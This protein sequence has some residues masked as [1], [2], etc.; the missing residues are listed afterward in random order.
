MRSAQ[1]RRFAQRLLRL[2][3][4]VALM[5]TKPGWG[6]LAPVTM[7]VSMGKSGKHTVA[8]GPR[9]ADVVVW[10]RALDPA[11]KA[12]EP[13]LTE[14]P[15]LTQFHKSFHPHLLVI[16]V[17]TVVD[18]PNRDPFFHN[19]FSLFEGKRIDL[20]LYEAGATNSVRFDRAGVSFLFCN[21]HPEMSAV[22]VVVDTPYFGISDR[23]GSISIANIPNG[24]YEVH[25]WAER[26]LPDALKRLT[27]VV[28]ISNSHRAL[29]SVQI[30]ENPN[31]TLV[32][33]NKYGEDYVPAPSTDYTHP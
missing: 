26:G 19:V 28:T 5:V 10:L 25:Y 27:R 22:V 1:I 9:D 18:F 32:H 7:Q 17:G 6:Q 24:R 33:K 3:A 14:R 4:I 21:I 15:K 11:I 16:R 12:A 29:D 23:S 8:S 20:G 2:C 30:A 13:P 31:F